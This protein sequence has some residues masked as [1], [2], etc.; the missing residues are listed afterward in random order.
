VTD[1]VVLKDRNITL[2]LL[3][4]ANLLVYLGHNGLMDFDLD[5]YP[6]GRDGKSRDVAVLCCKSAQ[7]FSSHLRTARANPILLT[8]GF[9]A[10]E[11]YVLDALI[12]SWLSNTQPQQVQR[13]AAKAYNTY[14]KCGFKAATNLFYVNLRAE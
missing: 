9:M 11:A 8:T 2:Q 3:G 14:Q 10:P 13:A 7:Y 1:S 12:G 5:S 6:I 4:G